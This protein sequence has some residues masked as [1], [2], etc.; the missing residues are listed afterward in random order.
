MNLL[1]SQKKIGTTFTGP[2]KV[3]TGMGIPVGARGPPS[4]LPQIW[5]EPECVG[6]LSD[7]IAGFF[8]GSGSR[9]GS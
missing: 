2:S 3:G 7:R 6:I 8:V 9:K 4:T 5:F 1:I